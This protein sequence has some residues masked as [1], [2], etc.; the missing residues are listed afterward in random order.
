MTR[1]IS[2]N[3]ATWATQRQLADEYG[4]YPHK[5]PSARIAP[6]TR[7]IDLHHVR[8]WHIPELGLT[9]VHRAD[10]KAKQRFRNILASS[11][12]K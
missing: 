6:I 8:T 11:G 5:P 10:F 7:V 2:I 1:T 3:L 4:I 9:L 12:H